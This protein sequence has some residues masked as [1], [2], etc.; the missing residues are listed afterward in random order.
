[1][2]IPLINKLPPTPCDDPVCGHLICGKIR[3][4]IKEIEYIRAD[5]YHKSL[6]E[7]YEKRQEDLDSL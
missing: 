5:E 6:Q 7:K 3:D 1:M 2:E 4:F